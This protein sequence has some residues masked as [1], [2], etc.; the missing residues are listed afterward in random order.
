MV[1]RR[2]AAVH[3]RSLLAALVVVAAAPALGAAAWTAPPD[4]ISLKPLDP[5]FPVGTAEGMSMAMDAA[6]SATAVWTQTPS[7][8]A[9]AGVFA[10]RMV[11]GRWGAPEAISSGSGDVLRPHVALGPTGDATV[12]W[13]RGSLG[14]RAVQAVRRIGGRWQ[15][16]ATVAPAAS[17]GND[18]YVAADGPDSAVAAWTR[19]VGGDFSL[20]VARHVGGAWGAASDLPGAGNQ[21]FVAQLATGAPG[22]VTAVWSDGT[23]PG[24]ATATATAGSWGAVTSFPAVLSSTPS[25]ALNGDGNGVLVWAVAGG[26]VHAARRAGGVWSSDLAVTTPGN[27]NRGPVAAVD[28]AGNATVAWVNVRGDG[29]QAVQAVRLTRLGWEAPVEVFAAE[30]VMAI[31]LAIAANAAGDVTIVWNGSLGGLQVMRAATRSGGAWGPASVISVAA[32]GQG[33]DTLTP[34]EVA[35]DPLGRVAAAW[36]WNA[37]SANVVAASRRQGVPSAPGAPSATGA[38][39][40]A[41]VRWSAPADDGSSAIT[42]YTAVAAPGGASCTATSTSCRVDGL[43]DGTAYSFTVTATNA[44]GTGPASASSGPATPT[45]PARPVARL[46]ASMVLRKRVLITTGPVVRAVTRVAQ[47][48][49]TKGRRARAGACAIRPA[50]RRGA[51]RTYRCTTKLVP[52]RWTITT[53]ARDRA[54]VLARSVR[55]VRVR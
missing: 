44:E 31:R 11:D 41:E 12:T 1:A 34:F 22:Q 7:V 51:T 27:D 33:P 38:S 28:G 23:L 17:N 3:V 5:F 45:T 8:G 2:R 55:A 32:A 18:A 29:T 24:V 43:A 52:G 9:P 25:L 50:A 19:T 16:E 21:A 6:G 47:R 20:R 54:G 42:R 36:L 26:V 35:V 39:R 4:T 30:P 53:T 48:S 46:R 13:L 49:T 15:G 14:S 37:G 40:S 10:A